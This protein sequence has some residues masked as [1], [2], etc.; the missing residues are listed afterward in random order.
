[1]RADDVREAALTL[2]ATRGYHGTSMKDIAAALGLRAPSLYNHVESKQSLLQEIM[3]GPL[4]TLIREQQAVLAT[5][6]DVTEQLRRAMEAHVRFHTR[7][8]RQVR[9]GNNEI[10]NIEEPART[11]LLELRRRYAQPWIDLIERGVAEGRFESP[12]PHLSAFAMIEMG[13]GVALWFRAEGAL[14]ESQVAYYYGDM[15]LRLVLTR[16]GGDTPARAG[17][18][19][20]SQPDRHHPQRCP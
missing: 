8:Q 10:A 3:L 18:S 14:S 9:I 13:M 16:T 11:H 7:F 2:F 1:M 19:S 5:T 6:N 12:S 20:P 15:A 4:E 17:M